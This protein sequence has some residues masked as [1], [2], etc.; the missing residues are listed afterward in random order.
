MSSRKR[1]SGAEYK[2]IRENKQNFINKQAGSFTTFLLKQPMV[3]IQQLNNDSLQITTTSGLTITSSQDTQSNNNLNSLPSTS[4]GISD[5]SLHRI[6]VDLFSNS[7][8]DSIDSDSYDYEEIEYF[9]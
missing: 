4:H 6:E 5:N 9:G 7:D 3:D 2:K 8:R 1:L